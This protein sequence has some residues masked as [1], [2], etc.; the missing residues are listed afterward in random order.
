MLL[1]GTI[2]LVADE[3]QIKSQGEQLAALK[4]DL[5]STK[6]TLKTAE[7][8][9]GACRI[10]THSAECNYYNKFLYPVASPTAKISPTPNPTIKTELPPGCQETID[11]YMSDGYSRA[12]A[13][14]FM[15]RD[16]P[17]CAY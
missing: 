15:K 1:V 2:K 14:Q 6:V 4:I 17:E 13:N 10:D 12:L 11:A 3:K 5:D 16:R 8:A 9:I 7:T